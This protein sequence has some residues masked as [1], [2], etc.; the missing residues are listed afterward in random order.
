MQQSF[1]KSGKL[2]TPKGSNFAGTVVKLDVNKG[3]P[4]SIRALV[5]NRENQQER[6]EL[7]KQ[8]YP[9]ARGFFEN[10]KLKKIADEFGYGEDNFV[11]TDVDD[12]GKEIQVLYNPKGLDLGDYASVGRSVA[13]SMAGILGGAL[14][15]PAGPVGIASGIGLGAEAGGQLYDRAMDV[16]AKEYLDRGGFT[17]ETID[18]FTRV[19]INV[20]APEFIQ[21]IAKKLPNPF[22]IKGG[23]KRVLGVTDDVAKRGREI[24]KK[25]Q[26]FGIDIPTLGQVIDSGTARWFSTK[27]RQLPLTAD[28]YMKKVD[29][30]KTAL[31]NT[32]TNLAQQYGKPVKEKGA[33]GSLLKKQASNALQR[34]DDTQTKL[35]KDAA[36]LL[37]DNVR[38]QLPSVKAYIESLEE[39]VGEG[40][41]QKNLNDI[42][43]RGKKYLETVN[44]Q[45]GMKANILLANRTDNLEILR[46]IDKGGET[47]KA[48][49][50]K[51]NVKYFKDLNKAL[52]EDMQNLFENAGGN[53]VKKAFNKAQRYTRL[54]QTLNIQPILNP[55]VDKT[56]MDY[57]AYNFAMQG[58]KESSERI[59][60]IYKNLDEEG[61]KDLT[62]SI[63]DRMGFMKPDSDVT[64]E[65]FN[66]NTFL[67]NYNNISKSAKKIIFSDSQL[68]KNLDDL[69]DI[70]EQSQKMNAFENP[71]GTGAPVLG[72]ATFY[73]PLMY[74]AGSLLKGSLSE[75]LA[76]GTG[77]YVLPATNRFLMT[78]KTFMN[79]LLKSG[80][81][82]VENPN[83]FTKHV[84]RLASSLTEKNVDPEYKEAVQEYIDSLLLNKTEEQSPISLLENEVKVSENKQEPMPIAD[85]PTTPDVNLLTAQNIPQTPT[86]QGAMPPPPMAQ[87]PMPQAPMPQQG[88]IGGLQQGQKFSALFPQDTMGQLIAQRKA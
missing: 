49:V 10:D 78:N 48:G 24:L 38:S 7:L 16:L 13:E 65:A 22:N 3:A 66:P 73:G 79:W 85:A 2:A 31:A 47:G 8:Y 68:R 80:K 43:Q 14:A 41:E 34:F 81:D 52:F 11:Y 39:M 57:Q 45:G 56:K 67:K 30:F 64:E 40:L 83:N 9:D 51:A 70:M 60:N 32:V 44:K 87:A 82:I 54:N 33:I 77:A 74:S 86:A 59:K 21:Q 58:T 35:Y 88:G 69:V 20:V 76:V 4:L 46:A 62:A 53:E 1:L 28:D 29:E 12:N 42:I 75:A 6:L 36:D 5:G 19:G 61:K 84:T 71:S 23:V 25:A 63:F 37:D 72:V 26:K 27:L 18:A 15:S 55:L 50:N 17:Q